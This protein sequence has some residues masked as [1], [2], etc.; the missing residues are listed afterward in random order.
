MVK[1]NEAYITELS[2]YLRI[3][4]LEENN[5]IFLLY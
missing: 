1:V 5:N 2:V 3:S 4:I